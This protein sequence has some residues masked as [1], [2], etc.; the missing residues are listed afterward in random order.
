MADDGTRREFIVIRKGVLNPGA[1][2]EP[3][4][5]I[6]AGPALTR[7]IAL[8]CGSARR[9]PDQERWC[10]TIHCLPFFS[11]GIALL[12]LYIVRFIVDHASPFGSTLSVVQGGT[13]RHLT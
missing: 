12:S 4:S 3:R 7:R 1:E 8:L 13:T 9:A 2:R 6:S 11:S 10:C 5:L